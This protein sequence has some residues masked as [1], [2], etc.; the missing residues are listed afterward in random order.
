MNILDIN[1]PEKLNELNKNGFI[2]LF[3]KMLSNDG[4]DW[5][6]FIGLRFWAT[7]QKGHF[8]RYVFPDI[9]SNEKYNSNPY[10]NET[11]LESLE[12]EYL[13]SNLFTYIE[14]IFF[15]NYE[16]GKKEGFDEGY[17]KISQ[18]YLLYDSFKRKLYDIAKTLHLDNKY[19]KTEVI[20]IMEKWGVSKEEIM[21]FIKYLEFRSGLLYE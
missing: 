15:E 7:K 20:D 14:E 2:N 3:W 18:L 10:L 12:G 13:T 6:K 17:K 16:K 11:I 19:K 1:V 9:K 5:L 21:L 8:S 4:A